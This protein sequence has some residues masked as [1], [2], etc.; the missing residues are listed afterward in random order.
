M[1]GTLGHFSGTGLDS[2][3]HLGRGREHDSDSKLPLGSRADRR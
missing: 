1:D 2:A 3:R